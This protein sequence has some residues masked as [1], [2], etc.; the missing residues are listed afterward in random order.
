MVWNNVFHFSKFEPKQSSFVKKSNHLHYNK[1]YLCFD[2]ETS[3]NHED[4]VDLIQCWSYQFSFYFQENLYYGRNLRDFVECL[5]KLKELCA[6]NKQRYLIFVH[7]LSFDIQFLKNF[8]FEKF[9]TENYKI[10]AVDNH[11]IIS[12]SIA[13]F[14]FRCTYKLSNRSLAKWSL[15]LGTKNR[16]YKGAIDYNTMR[17]PASPLFRKDWK[18]QLLDVLV[19][20]ECIECEMSLHGYTH[21]NQLPLTS[22]GYVRLKAREF[23]KKEYQKNRNDFLKQRLSVEQYKLLKMEYAGAL[24]HQNRFFENR[25]VKGKIRHRDFVSHYPSQQICKDFP[26]G[27]FNLFGENL[28]FSD[29]KEIVKT[30]CCLLQMT[31]SNLKLKNKKI[32]LPILSVDKCNK[33][34]RG[35]I[36]CIEDNGRV[37]QLDGTVTLGLTEID[38]EMLIDCYDYESYNIDVC[39]CSVKGKLP[40]WLQQLV[41]YLFHSKSDL[42]EKLKKF[43]TIENEL[44][45]MLSKNLLNGIYGMTATD[46]VR[47]IYEMNSNTGEW[48]N[49]FLSQNVEEK[50]KKY[51]KSKN[52]IMSFQFG[53]WTTSHARKELYD[54]VKI[55]GFEHFLYCDTDSIFYL[56]SDKIE[57]KIE[58]MN[59]ILRKEND[60]NNYFIETENNK[61]YFNQFELKKEEII[62]FKSLHSKCYAYVTKDKQLH[63]TVAGVTRFG[64]GGVSRETELG[65]IDNLKPDFTFKKCGGTRSI[66]VEKNDNTDSGVVIRHVNKTLSAMNEDFLVHYGKEC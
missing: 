7:N 62:K 32:T 54:F 8:L 3:D 27:K 34:K 35:A 36:R 13:N 18:Y 1:D 9:G 63:C 20:K 61:Y 28:S 10:I 42:K 19:L 11:K 40:L 33:G 29:I 24:S 31:F 57:K 46:I 4:D 2:C 53:A 59:T 44:N 55:I 64:E 45:L 43:E 12:F 5:G 56:S 65:C 23:F 50:L 22:T 39:Y 41:K 66:Y 25:I 52:N 49:D 17:T 60:E 16:K 26:I 37:L 30:H 47:I 48:S 6:N 51:Y 14:E 58:R 21:V 38:L 15:D